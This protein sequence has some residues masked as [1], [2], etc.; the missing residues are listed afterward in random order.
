VLNPDKKLEICGVMDL[1]HYYNEGYAVVQ[2]VKTEGEI[3]F[4]FDKGFIKAILFGMP[5]KDKIQALYD[6]IEKQHA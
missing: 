5:S 6:W 1:Q 2:A 3:N 4:V